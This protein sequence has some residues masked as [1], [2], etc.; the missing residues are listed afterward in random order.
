MT[1]KQLNCQVARITG[2]PLLSLR[3]LG[4]NLAAPHGDDLEPEDIRLVLD[5]PFCGQP[6]PYPGPA[7][8]GSQT[9]GECDRCDVYFDFDPEE[10]YPIAAGARAKGRPTEAL[11][12]F[13]SD[14][15]PA[16]E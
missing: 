8:D 1:Q 2:E 6:V 12:R 5:C 3:F 14:G 13:G 15:N 11:Q 10:V 7:A 4:F 16:L 9:M